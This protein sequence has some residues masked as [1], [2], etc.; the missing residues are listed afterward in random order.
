AD[1]A[2]F[3]E[4]RVHDALRPEV[5]VQVLCHAEH[6]AERPDV[7]THEEHAIVVLHRLA[8]ARIEGF[9]EGK[10]LNVALR[11]GR[12]I[13]P[14]VGHGVVLTH[15]SPPRDA[16]YSRSHSYCDCVTGWGSL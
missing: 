11:Q 5:A 16:S 10:L 14:L 7:L 1:D 8:Q 12:D 15:A 2:G 3:R 13:R 4:R 6:P 9:G